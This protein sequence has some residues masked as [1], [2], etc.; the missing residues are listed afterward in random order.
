M[1]VNNE[2][3]VAIKDVSDTMIKG[4]LILIG[5]LII[6]NIQ[7]CFIGDQIRQFRF[8]SY[9]LELYNKRATIILPDKHSYRFER[10]KI[11]IDKNGNINLLSNELEKSFK[12]SDIKII[13]IE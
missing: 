13:T 4:F 1:R 10:A 9:N 12:L 8:Q 6:V 11:T 5:I 3:V 7:I 2:K